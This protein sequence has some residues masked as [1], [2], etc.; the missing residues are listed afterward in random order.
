MRILTFDVEEWFHILDNESTKTEADWNRYERR[1]EQN[2]GRILEFLDSKQLKATFF[3]LGWVAREFPHVIRTIAEYGH[4]IASHSDRHQLVFEQKRN[5]FIEDL[6]RSLCE[7]EDI[8]GSK[9]ISYRAP[10]FS[11]MKEHDWVFEALAMHGIEIDCS[12]FPA[13]RAHGGFASF[14]AARPVWVEAGGV[15]LKEFPINLY[16]IAGQP[17]VFSGGG[18]FRLLP[19]PFISYMM[20]RSDYVMTYFHPRDF[21]PLQPVIKELGLM[22]KFKSYYGLTGAF[23][24]FMR[25]VSDS[26]FIDLKTAVDRYDWESADVITL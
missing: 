17:L 1:L 23:K 12:V 25:L 4:E 16:S 8:I 5:E 13:T 6:H 3:C 10:G 7:L 22:R 14:G 19:Y 26:E 18:Y 9:V 21:D 24:K 2:M 20:R 15:R 11:L